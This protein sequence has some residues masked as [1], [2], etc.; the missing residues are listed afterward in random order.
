VDHTCV[1]N[2][3][4]QVTTRIDEELADLGLHHNTLDEGVQAGFACVDQDLEALDQRVD[5]HRAEC[6]KT[7]EEFQAAEG[8]IEALTA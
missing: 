5:C 2:M 8:Q 7:E 3:Q 6:V 4:T 1:I